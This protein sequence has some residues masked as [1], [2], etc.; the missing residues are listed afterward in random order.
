M[1]LT[2]PFPGPRSVLVMDN[3]RIHHAQKVKELVENHGLWITHL[4]TSY[5]SYNSTGCRIE[6]L[7]A[8]SPDYNPIEQAFAVIKKYIRRL[9]K[10][11]TYAENPQYELYEACDIITAE[12]AR[13]FFYHSGY[14]VDEMLD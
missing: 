9:G 11:F 4:N 14:H 2:G 3:A 6:Y 10:Q 13:S 5:W 8:Y 7:P 12:H 1:P